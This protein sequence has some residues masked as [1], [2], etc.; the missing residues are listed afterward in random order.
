MHPPTAYALKPCSS[1]VC[2]MFLTASGMS[3]WKFSGMI[4]PY[5]NIY[6]KFKESETDNDTYNIEIDEDR[7]VYETTTSEIQGHE[8]IYNYAIQH[9]RKYL[10]DKSKLIIGSDHFI[11]P[12]WIEK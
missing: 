2:I 11:N 9:I 10:L 8:E 1:I 4:S 3:I 12:N 5:N 6:Y 7:H